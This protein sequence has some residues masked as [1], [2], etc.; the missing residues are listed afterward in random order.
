MIDTGESKVQSDTLEAEEQFRKETELREDGRLEGEQIEQQ[1]LNQG[2]DTGTYPS[3]H[4]GVN[5]TPEFSVRPETE[6]TLPTE[7]QIE[8]RA[9]DL[10]LQRGRQ[11]GHDSE[12]WLTAE[13][14]LKQR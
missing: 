10:Y 6:Q 2:S 8:A 12:D 1:V 13:K 7:R 4:F 9:Y 11:D 5:W 14:E 3:T